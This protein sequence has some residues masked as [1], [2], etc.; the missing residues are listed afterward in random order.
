LVQLF[1]ERDQP[2]AQALD[3]PE[4]A[5]VVSRQKPRPAAAR[6]HLEGVVDVDVLGRAQ[7]RHARA[8]RL[9]AQH[10]RE[11][12]VHV[13]Q[14]GEAGDLNQLVVVDLGHDQKSV[15]M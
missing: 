9:A 8:A 6:A 10:R 2:P 4:P 3:R 7:R 14:A 15:S 13:V 12:T 5:R 11:L 1:P